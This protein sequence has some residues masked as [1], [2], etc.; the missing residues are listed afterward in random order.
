MTFSQLRTGDYF[1]I[2]GMISGYV[3]RK[4]NDSQCSINCV[5]QPIRSETEVRRLTPTEVINHFAQEH[6]EFRQFKNAVII[7]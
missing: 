7:H 2:P 1:R 3:Y 6:Q 4:A 5:L